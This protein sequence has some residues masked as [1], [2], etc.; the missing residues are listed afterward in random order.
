MNN[1]RT[2]LAVPRKLTPFK[3]PY[4]Y[5]QL[6]AMADMDC[7]PLI[8]RP[9]RMGQLVHTLV[10]LAFHGIR[11]EKGWQV[12]HINFVRDDN[13]PENL[14]WVPFL[15]NL[16]RQKPGAPRARGEEHHNAK[17][18]AELVRQIRE[19]HA[20][21]ETCKSI[22]ASVGVSLHSVWHVAVR[23]V[24]ARRVR[25]PW[26]V[27]TYL[28]RALPISAQ[29][30]INVFSEREPQT[31]KA[32]VV[33][34]P[35]P[36]LRLF[37][38]IADAPARGLHVMGADLYVVYG[39]T[40][41]RVSAA[42][43]ATAIGNVP[44]GGP[45]SLDSDGENLA[46]VVPDTRQA[47]V[48]NR[49]AGTLAPIT[50]P[51]FTS[52]G[53][54]T[55][56]TVISG[57][58]IFSRPNSGEFFLSALGD[59]QT[60]PALDFATAEGAPDHLIAPMRIGQD[61]WLFGERSIEVWSNVGSASFPFVR[62]AGGFVARGVA[63][64]FSIDVRE[65]AAV[66]LG[67][68]R[69][70]YTAVGVQPQRISTHAVEQ[71]IAGY[72]RVNDAVGFVYEQEGHSFYVLTFPSA[73]DTWVYD[74][75]T[76]VWHERES[77]GFGTWRATLAV[78]YAGGVI[79]GDVREGKMWLARSDLGA[80]GRGADH[81]GGDRHRLPRRGRAG[82]VSRLS[83]D[84][85]AGQGLVSGQGSDPEAWL[86]WSNDGGHTWSNESI[87]GLGRMGQ[88]RTGWSGAGWGQAVTGCSACNGRTRSTPR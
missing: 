29:R 48:V 87:R 63:A 18:T 49:T 71:A 67:D 24:E 60:F 10:C 28:H 46:I 73:G 2:P 45:V 31:A 13:R 54:A 66:W 23:G 14:R 41:L 4:G 47:F 52:G 20:A 12:D 43:V 37:G 40:V 70:V 84:F 3:N 58:F 6:G 88:Y 69:A 76:A 8:A 33:L 62:I 44:A 85:A 83:V 26:A 5:F 61:L 19:R 72:E 38:Q 79:A 32:Q 59:P 25:L 27:G 74:F 53:G 82:R 50:A 81:P 35:S 21:G 16:R 77:E 51:E 39:A 57:Y 86:S 17:L 55:G 34:L 30:C 9:G 65:G 1:H 7:D 80:R 36:G 22:G 64:Q 11:P 78:A 15:D 75:S 56:V 68:N 42:G